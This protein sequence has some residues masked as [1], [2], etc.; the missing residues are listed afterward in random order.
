M[1]VPAQGGTPQQPTGQPM[2]NGGFNQAMTPFEQAAQAQPMAMNTVAQELNYQ[3]MNVSPQQM[4]QSWGYDPSMVNMSQLGGASAGSAGATMVDPMQAQMTAAQVQQADIDRFMNPYTDSVVDAS[5]SDI[6]RMSDM[7]RNQAAAEATAAGAFGGSRGALMEAEVLRNAMDQQARTGS[8][9]RSQGFVQAT[10]NA[11]QD[12]NR[13]QGASQFNA[14]NRLAAL[15]GNQNAGLQASIANAN[16]ATRASTANLQ[17]RLAALQ[18]NQSA[19]NNAAQFGQ[20]LNSA[21][22]QFNVANDF[23]GQQFNVNSGLQ[24]SQNRMAAAGS[25]AGLGGQSFNYGQILNGN[26]A[27]DG[28]TQRGI[29][30]A[31]IDAANGDWGGFT[32]AP[33]NALNGLIS[34]ISGAPIPTTTTNRETPGLLDVAQS[35]AAMYALLAGSDR[36]TK[37]NIRQI[38]KTFQGLNL[39]E[40]DWNDKAKGIGF[41]IYPTRGVMA[42]EVQKVIPEAVFERADGYLMVDYGRIAA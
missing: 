7:Q 30:Q 39:Y 34:A 25:L 11:Q 37:K 19:F 28:A 18:G 32:N 2:I 23:A 20:N 16:N 21:A 14:G 4:S 24:G 35:G 17:S 6:N 9:L 36:R 12:V 15:Q 13:R 26:L 40:W 3:P 41:D 33:N 1:I 8:Q 5:M 10:Q 38:G 27:Q 42:Q 31:L 22:E 29:T